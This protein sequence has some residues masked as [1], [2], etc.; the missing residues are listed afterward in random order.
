MLCLRRNR[1]RL[2]RGFVK[3]SRIILLAVIG[4]LIAAFFAFDLEQYFTL[5]YFR[6]QRETIEAYRAENPWLAG[7]LF[8]LVYVAFMALALP[9]AAL[10]TLVAGALFGVWLGV[11]IVSFASSIG[12]TLAFLLARYLFRDAVRS[13]FSRQLAAIDRGIEKDGAFYLFAMRLVPAFP[14]VAVNLAMAVTP[15]RTWTFYWVSQTGMLAGTVVYVN[16][17]AQLG[18]LE[19]LAG[20]LSPTLLASFALLGVFP[21][22]AKRA[23]EAYKARAKRRDEPAP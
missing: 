14:F 8:F 1:W 17:G 11:L 10:L 6:A 4:L 12:A 7:V 15:V 16:A 22:V 2:G 18:Q 13:R 20:I 23:L 19:S 3:P 9:A 21:I 5:E